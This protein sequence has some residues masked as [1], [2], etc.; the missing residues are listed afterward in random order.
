MSR[1]RV[2]V[3]GGTFDPI[4]IGHLAAVEDAASLLGLARVLFV[5]NRV[6]PHKLGKTIS[7]SAHRVAMVELS[8][9]DNAK[10]EMSLVELE[11][12]GP[13]YTLHTLRQLRDEWP[14][15][16][17][18]FLAGCDALGALHTW[19]QPEALLDEFAL[20]IMDRATGSPVDWPSVE[21]RFPHIR[22]RVTVL[23]VP[24]LAISADDIRRRVREGRPIKYYVV[25]LVE[26]YIRS[27]GLY[28]E[29]R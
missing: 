3:F 7:S 22:E 10:F 23:P 15:C 2:G 19:Y 4:H 27:H 16:E 28:R 21:R 11:R 6:P 14:E 13:S 8:I 17:L 12:E 26:R 9:A 20:V 25:P 5:P 29:S 1:E 24:Q 18:L